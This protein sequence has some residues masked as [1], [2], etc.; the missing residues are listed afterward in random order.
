MHIAW[1]PLTPRRPT[2][3][4]L[5]EADDDDTL[6]SGDGIVRLKAETDAGAGGFRTILGF[7][8][9]LDMDRRWTMTAFTVLKTQ[10]P[11][12]VIRAGR[13]R[14]VSAGLAVADPCWH[15]WALEQDARE[16]EEAERRRRA[17]RVRRGA[18][19]GCGGEYEE[20]CC[21]RDR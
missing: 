5:A 3:L 20:G 11:L 2:F 17:D 10:L 12:H 16:R 9:E 6:P 7:L 8:A 21:A 13:V 14:V 18:R 1:Q 15:G 4:R 19:R